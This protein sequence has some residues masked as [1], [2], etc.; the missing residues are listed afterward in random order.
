MVM[1]DL[2][3]QLMVVPD[4]VNGARIT[5]SGRPWTTAHKVPNWQGYKQADD[6]DGNDPERV[7]QGPSL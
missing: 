2:V 1:T 7:V 6:S 5:C 3:A 4:A